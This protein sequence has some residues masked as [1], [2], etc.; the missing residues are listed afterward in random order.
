MKLL[1]DIFFF[2]GKDFFQMSVREE[3]GHWHFWTYGVGTREEM[4]K[5]FTNLHLWNPDTPLEYYCYIPV[6]S[7]DMSVKDA[8]ASEDGFIL[9]DSAV[10]KIGMNN[11]VHFELNLTSI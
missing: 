2:R 5:F 11:K 10:K 6:V 4:S 9:K 7:I 1:P 3:S 8:I